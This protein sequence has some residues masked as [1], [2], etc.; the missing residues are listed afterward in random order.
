MQ[1][2]LYYGEWRFYIAYC[3]KNVEIGRILMEHGAEPEPTPKEK[4]IP[5]SFIKKLRE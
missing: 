4:M 2:R 3:R 1:S 5:D